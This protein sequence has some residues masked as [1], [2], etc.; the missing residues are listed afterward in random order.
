[1]G[2][3]FSSSQKVFNWYCN[4]LEVDLRYHLFVY[5]LPLAWSFLNLNMPK[6][7]FPD[8]A[9]VIKYGGV[10]VVYTNFAL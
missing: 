4:N 9:V 3:K 1:M 8:C 7:L 10:I 5:I 6:R 2:K